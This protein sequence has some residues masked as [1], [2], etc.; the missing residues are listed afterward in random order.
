MKNVPGTREVQI[1]SKKIWA[2]K[3]GE[4]FWQKNGGKKITFTEG[5][6]DNKEVPL[7]NLCFLRSLV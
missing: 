7:R 2:E 3:C 5:N 6:E 1:Q 4:D